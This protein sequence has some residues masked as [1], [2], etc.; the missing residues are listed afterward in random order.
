M[1]KLPKPSRRTTAV[2]AAVACASATAAVVFVNSAS[3]D[4]QGGRQPSTCSLATLNGTYLFRGDGEHFEADG[5]SAPVAY[6]GHL[7]FNGAGKIDKGIISTRV[8]SFVDSRRS[9][10]GTY[11]VDANCSGTFSPN[12][13]THPPVT[14]DLFTSPSGDKYTY[15]QTDLF[16]DVYDVDA[17]IAERVSR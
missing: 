16:N 13:P 3:A 10:D 8:G 17:T 9:F 2:T 4:S 12:D 11:T 6:A 7:H 15:L 14:F 1:R 5:S